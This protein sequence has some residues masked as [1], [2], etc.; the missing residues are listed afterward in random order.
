MALSPTQIEPFSTTEMLVA[1]NNGEKYAVSYVELRFYCPCAGCVDENT[2]QRTIQR[3]SIN[4]EVRTTD[5]T[6][7][8]RYAVQLSFS[9]G[10]TTGIFSFDHL[11]EI[12]KNQGRKLSA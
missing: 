5:A 4:P 10:H 6:L 3:T 12:C 8:G 9:D 7:V 2:G 1:W 11:L